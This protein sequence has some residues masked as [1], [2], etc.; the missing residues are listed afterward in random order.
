[1]AIAS[2][3]LMIPVFDYSD[4]VSMRVT[5]NNFGMDTFLLLALSKEL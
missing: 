1:M 5:S 4:L 3:L 2:G